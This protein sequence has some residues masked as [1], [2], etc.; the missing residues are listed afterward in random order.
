MPGYGGL[1]NALMGKLGSAGLGGAGVT[2]ADLTII[3]SGSISAGLGP[4]FGDRGNAIIFTG[5]SNVLTMSGG[6]TLTGNLVIASGLLT[7]AQTSE[8][9]TYGTAI[10]GGGAVAITTAGGSVVT[11]QGISTYSGGTTVT[12]GSTLAIDGYSPIGSGVLTLQQS[13]DSESARDGL[14]PRQCDP[15]RRHR[16]H[17]HQPEGHH[18]RRDRR[19][20]F[21]RQHHQDRPGDADPLGHQQ[22][23]RPDAGPERRAAGRWLDRLFEPDRSAER[24]GAAGHRHGGHDCRSTAAAP[25]RRVRRRGRR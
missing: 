5:G 8:N 13:A 21:G 17:L 7:L 22:L 6:A 19:R 15:R 12:T 16:G 1:G 9:W 10:T 4:H 11:L 24:G 20:Y 25:S 18:R 3:N 14:E 2:G 23:Q